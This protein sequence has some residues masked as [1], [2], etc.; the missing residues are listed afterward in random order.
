MLWGH[1]VLSYLLSICKPYYQLGNVCTD[2]IASGWNS[3]PPT[4]RQACSVSCST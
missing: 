2:V 4:V 1:D 3:T